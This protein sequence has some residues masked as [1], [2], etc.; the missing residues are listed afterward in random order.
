MW[1]VSVVTDSMVFRSVCLGSSMNCPC[2]Y[3][4]LWENDF[5]LALEWSPERLGK[6]S[7]TSMD[8][9]EDQMREFL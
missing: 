1:R 2:Q 4:W 7:F 5:S 8:C 3:V 6:A 9:C